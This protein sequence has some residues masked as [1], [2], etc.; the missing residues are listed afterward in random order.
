M[1]LPHQAIIE[2]V[3]VV[4]RPIRGHVILS[5]DALRE[6]KEFLRQVPFSFRR[7][8]SCGTPSLD[9]PRSRNPFAAH[10]SSYAE[11][12]GLYEI[13]TEDLQHDGLYGTVRVGNPFLW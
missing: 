7:R 2:F 8:R 3:S 1:R 12:Y 5:L 10:M 11:H 9:V 4:T 13:L 6:P